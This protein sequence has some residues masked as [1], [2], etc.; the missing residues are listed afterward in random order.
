[1]AIIG[2]LTIA[3]MSC[4]GLPP[5]EERGLLWATA[6]FVEYRVPV[7]VP[8]LMARTPAAV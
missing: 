2:D 4:A 6:E 8:D 3:A 7:Q 1:V 5:S